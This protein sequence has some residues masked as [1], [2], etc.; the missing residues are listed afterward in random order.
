M[1]IIQNFK[2]KDKYFLN[3]MKNKKQERKK[4]NKIK[5]DDNEKKEG[6]KF[7]RGK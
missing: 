1:K 6:K 5:T 3:L 2:I 4:Y 7:G